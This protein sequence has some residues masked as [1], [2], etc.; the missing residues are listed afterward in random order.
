MNKSRQA[1]GVWLALAT[2]RHREAEGSQIESACA[3]DQKSIE[4]ER[5]VRPSIEGITGMAQSLATMM[6][7]P[8]GTPV[9]QA[10]PETT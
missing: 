5:Q 4:A 1:A 3:V 9:L 2:A 10:L 7:R 6:A 8:E